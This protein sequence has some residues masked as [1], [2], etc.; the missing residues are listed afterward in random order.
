[1][2]N[3]SLRPLQLTWPNRISILRLLLVAPLIVLLLNQYRWD[4]ARHAALGVFAI[5]AISDFVDGQLARRLH[6]QTRL[7]AILD[8]LA[9]KVLIMSSV[10]LLS[11]EP[12]A[13]PGARSSPARPSW[14]R[15]RP[16]R[17]W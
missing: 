11:L 15:R 10:I 6:M 2:S 5:M 17:S 7:G 9:D 3:G 13:V 16:S 4:F 1:M 12:T 8:P 14:A